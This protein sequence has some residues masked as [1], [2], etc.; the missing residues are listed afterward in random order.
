MAEDRQQL[1]KYRILEKLGRGGFATV[2]RALDTTLDRE[3]APKVLD[4]LLWVS[5]ALT[6]Q[7]V[8]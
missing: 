1:G 2:Y 8:Q 3:V 5:G 6:E 4:L 7:R